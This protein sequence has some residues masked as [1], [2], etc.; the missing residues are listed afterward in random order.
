MKIKVTRPDGT[1]IEAEGTAEECERIA[2]APHIRVNFAPTPG[3]T[4]VPS[5]WPAGPSLP[6][7]LDPQV[8]YGPGWSITGLTATTETRS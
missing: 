6:N 4:F 7:P 3:P 8:W 2:A 5:N 1:V